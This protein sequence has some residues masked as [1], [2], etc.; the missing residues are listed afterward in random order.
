MQQASKA[1]AKATFK[2]QQLAWKI[3]GVWPSVAKQR[4][5]LSEPVKRNSNPDHYLTVSAIVRNEE[6]YLVEWIEFHR[7]LGVS[8]FFIYDN[9]STDNTLDVL[10]PYELLGLVTVIPWS[11]F[12]SGWE[13]VSGKSG[14]MQRLAMLHS[15]SN[16]GHQ[17]YWM[18]F[19]DVDEFL[20]PVAG[21]S[22]NTLLESYDDLDSLS[23]Y[24]NMFGTSGHTRKP[25][26]LVI[27]NFTE[28]LRAPDGKNKNLSRVKS[29]VKPSAVA[30]VYN[31]HTLIMRDGTPSSRNERRQLVSHYDHSLSTFSN[32][33]IRINHYYSKSLSE[34]RA[35]QKVP[36]NGTRQDFRGNDKLLDLIQHDSI[37]DVTIQRF[38]PELRK[39]VSGERDY[40][41][42]TVRFMH[43][44]SEA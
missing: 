43:P 25:T 42:N 9:G 38:L 5:W 3:A 34:Y 14:R 17:S 11:N 4:L 18:A 32:D 16:F 8:H 24:W 30:G 21:K 44:K 28:R 1:K 26:G 23:V 10:A 31:T 6:P 29:I 15:L 27:E 39:K 35:R 2:L 36:A 33:I 41:Q 7:M 20:Y 37:E 19:I 12:L 13:G 22:L 40:L